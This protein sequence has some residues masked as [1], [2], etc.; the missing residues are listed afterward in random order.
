MSVSLQ[1]FKGFVEFIALLTTASVGIAIS[2]L[3]LSGLLENMSWVSQKITSLTLLLLGFIATYLVFERRGKM[4]EIL[5]LINQQSNKILES[6]DS[7]SNQ[8]IQS[9][10]GVNIIKFSSLGKMVAYLSKRLENARKLD[11]TSWG[12]WGNAFSNITG[13]DVDLRDKH[14]KVLES[15]LARKDTLLRKIFVFSKHDK[16]SAKQIQKIKDNITGY[17][18]SYFLSG[19]EDEPTRFP[20]AIIDE[21]E[22]LIIG[23]E[24]LLAVKQPD[25]TNFFKEFYES[26]WEKS[27]K[28]REGSQVSTE[29]VEELMSILSANST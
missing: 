19:S 24:V 8:T 15:F 16:I 28:L 20:F 18:V 23:N 13:E 25:I 27:K 9:L 1:K 29:N 17:G 2:I 21:E 10:Q 26:N 6:I 3:D 4:E 7:S 22:V 14:N 11:D 5:T 12:N